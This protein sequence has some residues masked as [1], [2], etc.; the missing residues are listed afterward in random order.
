VKSIDIHYCS[1]SI[2]FYCILRHCSSLSRLFP[3]RPLGQHH[4]TSWLRHQFLH[5]LFMTSSLPFNCS[6]SSQIVYVALT[7]LIYPLREVRL[8]SAFLLVGQGSRLWLLIVQGY[9]Q[10]NGHARLAAD[11]ATDGP[12]FSTLPSYRRLVGIATIKVANGKIVASPAVSG[13]IVSTSIMPSQ[14]C[15]PYSFWPSVGFFNFFLAFVYLL[16]FFYLSSVLLCN[17]GVNAQKCRNRNIL[18]RIRDGIRQ[19]RTE[20][21]AI[22]GMSAL[23]SLSSKAIWDLQEGGTAVCSSW[24]GS[25]PEDVLRNSQ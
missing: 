17:A 23:D 11:Y 9:H 14:P 8:R 22:E 16:G 10:I 5:L 24:R 1:E 12:F 15:E 25:L 13:G 21:R 4:M 18:W 20:C 7:Q 2:V 3:L 19:C 6:A